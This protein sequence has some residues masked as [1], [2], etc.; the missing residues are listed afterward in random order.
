MSVASR[1]AELRRP[2]SHLHNSPADLP[3]DV[4]QSV[5]ETNV[6][7][8]ERYFC[9]TVLP[10]PS[11]TTKNDAALEEARQGHAK[12]VHLPQAGQHEVKGS[13]RICVPSPAPAPDGMEQ[14]FL[15]ILR[16]I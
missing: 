1:L 13:R 9:A 6:L 15:C 2:A 10:S 16:S 4:S 8:Q 3:S 5:G 7:K 14:Y 12:S 11:K